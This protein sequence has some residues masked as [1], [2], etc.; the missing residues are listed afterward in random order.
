MYGVGG[1]DFLGV[2]IPNVFAVLPTFGSS[3]CDAFQA[4]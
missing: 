4:V 1:D 3:I 2:K